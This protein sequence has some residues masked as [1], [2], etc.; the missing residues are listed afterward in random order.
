MPREQLAV[1][2][3]AVDRAASAASE[4]APVELAA[5]RDKLSRAQIAQSKQDYKLARQLAEEATA[6]AD[7]A[8]ARSR[9][10]R[11]DR[12]L[13]EVRASIAQLRDEMA[14]R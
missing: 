5:A 10:A 14:R 12:A 1:G 4:E 8:A 3:A 6:D 2:R 7:L 9:A 11:A 13:A